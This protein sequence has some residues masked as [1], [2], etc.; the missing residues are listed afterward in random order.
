MTFF[1]PET[2]Q[3][4]LGHSRINVVAFPNPGLLSDSPLTGCTSLPPLLSLPSPFSSKQPRR[5]H[6]LDLLYLFQSA[7][8]CAMP[9]V[10]L[11]SRGLTVASVTAS[12]SYSLPFPYSESPLIISMCLEKFIAASGPTNRTLA[13][14]IPLLPK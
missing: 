2:A 7:R 12:S 11:I 9:T 14:P 3:A 8:K 4:D 5:Y 1:K 6:I 13:P 10:L